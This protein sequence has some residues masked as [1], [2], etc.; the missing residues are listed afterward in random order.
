MSSPPGAARRR[1]KQGSSFQHDEAR[2]VIGERQRHDHAVR[3]FLG[4]GRR[5]NCSI[6]RVPDLG[7]AGAGKRRGARLVFVGFVKKKY[8]SPSWSALAPLRIAWLSQ[9]EGKAPP[10]AIS[11]SRMPVE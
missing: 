6:G 4:A 8:T 9:F 1:G 11:K 2:F 7:L 5:M 10:V 3:R